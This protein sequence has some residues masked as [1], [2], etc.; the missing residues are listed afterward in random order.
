M[1]NSIIKI[2]MVNF[3]VKMVNFIIKIVNFTIIKTVNFTIIK[4]VNFKIII[5]KMVNFTI[6]ITMKSLYAKAR[7]VIFV[8]LQNVKDVE[9]WYCINELTMHVLQNLF[10][11]DRR[12]LA[13]LD[14][15]HLI[16]MTGA[17]TCITCISIKSNMRTQLSNLFSSLT[18]ET[19]HASTTNKVMT[20]GK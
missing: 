12:V 1:V 6:I 13:T 2:K 8:N 17:R 5:I 7:I 20:I 4:T 18:K 10:A 16:N 3:I 14:C 9:R 19:R 11:A 15:H